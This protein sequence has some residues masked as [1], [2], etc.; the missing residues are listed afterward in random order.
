MWSL[1][2]M[3]LYR[4]LSVCLSVLFVSIYLSVLHSLASPPYCLLCSLFIHSHRPLFPHIYFVFC[5]FLNSGVHIRLLRPCFVRALLPTL[6]PRH[7]SYIMWDTLMLEHCFK[8]CPVALGWPHG[9]RL[10]T[11]VLDH[12][13]QVFLTTDSALLPLFSKVFQ[14][15]FWVAMVWKPQQFLFL[16]L[17]F[18]FPL[19]LWM[20]NQCPHDWI[21]AIGQGWLGLPE[22]GAPDC[23]HLL[24]VEYLRTTWNTDHFPSGNHQKCWV[25]QPPGDV[26]RAFQTPL[27]REL[28]S[29]H[30]LPPTWSWAHS[31]LD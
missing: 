25:N 15:I 2:P 3:C 30:A 5:P 16:Y 8:H 11:W 9:I 18:S 31:S 28:S 12:A 29:A 24:R 17:W 26:D 6:Y 13:Q 23:L 20:Y 22:V 4:M 14:A 19:D 27:C 21:C 10:E 7:L 1:S